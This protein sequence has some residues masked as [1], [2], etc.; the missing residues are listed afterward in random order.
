MLLK[1][2]NTLNIIHVKHR[3]KKKHEICAPELIKTQYITNA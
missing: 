1:Q 3:N 2:E